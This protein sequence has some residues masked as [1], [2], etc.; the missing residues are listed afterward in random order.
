MNA[1]LQRRWRRRGSSQEHFPT[2]LYAM[3]ELSASGRLGG[4]SDA[5]AW[6]PHGRAF[7]IVD[8][9]ALMDAVAPM[10]FR[11]TKIRL[12]RLQLHLWGFKR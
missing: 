10:F 6:R 12:F 4:S 3:L 11:L 1:E 2:K 8:E 7:K 9:G 5:V